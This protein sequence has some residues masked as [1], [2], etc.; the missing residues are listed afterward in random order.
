MVFFAFFFLPKITPSIIYPLKSR[1]SLSIKCFLPLDL[2]FHSIFPLFFVFLSLYRQFRQ[3]RYFNQTD[4]SYQIHVRQ[5]W[6]LKYSRIFRITNY[7]DFEPF[8]FVI[9][10]DIVSSFTGFS[11]PIHVFRCNCI[12]VLNE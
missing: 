4:K 3:Q 5:I 10:L 8:L 1:F 12:T 9:N 7:V 11:T 2:S 6:N